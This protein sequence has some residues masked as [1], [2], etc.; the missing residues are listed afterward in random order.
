MGW[1]I[2]RNQA[3][4]TIFIDKMWKTKVSR[5]RILGAFLHLHIFNKAAPMSVCVVYPMVDSVI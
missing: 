5:K 4:G 1:G 2:S 3:V